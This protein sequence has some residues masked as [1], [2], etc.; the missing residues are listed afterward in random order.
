VGGRPDQPAFEGIVEGFL[1]GIRDGDIFQGVPSRHLRTTVPGLGSVDVYGALRAANPSPYMFHMGMGDDGVLLGASP[2]TC[3]RVE[4]GVVEIRPIAGTVPRGRRDDGSLDEDLDGRLAL[5]M[6]LDPKEQ[7]EHA[8]LVDLARNDV[9]RVSVPGTTR[10]VQQMAVEKYA[11][12]QH[13]VSRVQGRL[14]PELDAL[15]AYRAAANMGTLTGA[16]KVKAME[17]IRTA[18]P[19][20]RGFY[21][22]AMGYL[23]ADGTFDS[24]IVIR[25]LRQKGD[26]VHTRAGAGIVLDSVPAREFA[27]TEHKARAV[28][29]AVARAAASL[30]G[31]NP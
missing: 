14:R 27:E 31:R 1:A 30:H 16:P 29:Q 12:V 18:E 26:T 17:M 22:G 4:E 10:V 20:A 11:H 15:H 23:L 28:R 6:T 13:L 24:C 7:A 2:E 19:T 5:A 25:S 3:V 21:G 8:M 9:A